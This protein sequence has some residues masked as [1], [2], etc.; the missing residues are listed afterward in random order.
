MSPKSV[1]DT[2]TKL[3]LDDLAFIGAYFENNMIGTRAYL[4]LHPDSSYDAARSSA[5]VILAKPSIRAEIKRRLEERAM[6][7]EEAIVRVGEMAR[8]DLHP[9]IKI[10]DDG[11]VWFDFSDPRAKEYLYLIKKIKTKRERRIVGS[12]P[13]AEPWEGEWVEVEL[14][15]AQAALRDILKM[16][17]KL[18]KATQE[19]ASTE[20]APISI[21]ADLLAPSFSASYRAVRSGKY[22]EFLEYGGRGSTK[23][24]FISLAIIE[25]LVNNPDMHVLALRQV[26]NTI[27]ESVY[28]QLDWAIRELGLAEKFKLTTNPMQITYLPTGQKIFFR[29]A[30]DAK[31]IKSIKPPFG[32]IGILWLEE[33]DQFHGAESVRTIEQSIRGGDKLYNFKSWNPPRTAASWVSKYIQIP[34]EGQWQHKSDYRDVPIEWLGKPWF[35]EAEH[36]REVNP[37]AYEHE[38]LGV[39]NGNGG[40]VF[41]NVTIRAITD[42]EMAQFDHIHNGLDW[43][44]FP[45]PLSFGKM[46]YDAN[47]LKLYIFSEYRANKKSNRKTYDDLVQKGLLSPEDLII[48]DSAEPKSIGDYRSY[49]ANIRGAEKGPDSVDYSMKWLQ[50]LTEIVIDPVRA[51]MHAEEFLNY[52]LEQDKDG[53]YISEYPDKNNHAIDDVR[54]ALNLI[55]RQRGK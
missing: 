1:S 52:E 29:G 50:S 26:A 30:D 24:S 48:A 2:P 32:Y 38:Y 8:A 11:F 5:P 18:D 55:W 51:P 19:N 23:S 37:T 10:G 6:S 15:D 25:L 33:L 40:Q 13:M 31:K 39:A 35:D 21:P 53:N 49:G 20:S 7:A 45:D 16:H 4:S 47:H 41:E 34:K 28:S 44:Y 36:L 46:H 14:H 12:G 42:E 22:T 54:Y 3:T 9:F 43:G 17:G 27:R